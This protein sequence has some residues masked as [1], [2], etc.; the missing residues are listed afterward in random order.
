MKTLES[1]KRQLVGDQEQ[2][3]KMEMR[4]LRFGFGTQRGVDYE[5]RVML[6]KYCL[7]NGIPRRAR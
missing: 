4:R 5:Q 1:I 6:W 7:M 2:I 3:E